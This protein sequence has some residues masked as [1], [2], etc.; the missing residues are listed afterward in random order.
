MFLIKKSPT[1]WVLGVLLGFGL[2]W[3]FRTFLLE[4][5][6]GKLVGWFSS[7]AKLLFRFAITLDY[8]KIRKF[9]TYWSLEGVNTRKS[10]IITGM[11]NWNWTKFGAGFAGFFQRVLSPKTG[12]FW[13]LLRCLNPEPNWRNC[14]LRVH[15]VNEWKIRFWTSWPSWTECYHHTTTRAY[16]R[17]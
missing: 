5:A 13:V 1:H 11:T 16:L 15:R 17:V 14:Q 6:V 12:G 2:Y 9:I 10:L 4:R 3:G 7:S 8:L